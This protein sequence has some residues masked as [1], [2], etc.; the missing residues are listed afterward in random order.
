MIRILIVD[1]QE[2]VHLLLMDFLANERDIDLVGTAYNGQAAIELVEQLRPDVVL[3]D[4]CMP[5]MDGLST[6]K[7]I[8]TSY[9]QTKV[10]I[11]S[12]QENEQFIAQTIIAGANG[13]LLK[14]SLVKNLTTAIQTVLHGKYYLDPHLAASNVLQ[15]QLPAVYKPSRLENLTSWLAKEIITA[16]RSQ[17]MDK[18]PSQEEFL[19]N[20]GLTMEQESSLIAPIIF[21]LERVSEAIDL[22]K[23][24][25]LPFDSLQKSSWIPKNI[26]LNQMLQQI[27]DTEAEIKNWFSLNS[28]VDKWNCNTSQTNLNI[29]SI[30]NDVFTKFKHNIDFVWHN[31]G[32]EII[33]NWLQELDI[34][35]QA[36]RVN[37]KKHYQDYLQK[38]TSAWS[39]YNILSNKLV[40][41]NK[42]AYKLKNWESVWK[43]LL[44]AFKF[45]LYATLY[46]YVIEQIVSELIQQTQTYKNIICKTDNLLL[47]LQTEFDQQTSIKSDLLPLLFSS[48]DLLNPKQFRRELESCKGYTLNHWGVIDSITQETIRQEI[49]VKLNPLAYQFYIECCQTAIS[50]ACDNFSENLLK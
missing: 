12:S 15:Q 28:S 4:L 44:L 40:N 25:S 24:I 5:V 22:F 26:N 38:E 35:L 2:A 13:Y 33:L 31:L 48:T 8:T 50:S 42:Q 27:I 34:G 39:A 7:L 47:D 6:T 11:F 32:S 16:W 41:L 9:D 21:K 46:S 45:K 23:R 19:V 30:K 37:Y 29:E 18:T 1:D 20:A 17:A 49:I 36:I 3:L 10:I 43:A 14:Q